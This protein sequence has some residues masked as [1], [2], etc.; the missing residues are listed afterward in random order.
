MNRAAACADS[1]A[2]YRVAHSVAGAARNV[3]ADRLAQRASA[4]EQKVGSLSPAE[5][6]AELAA[7]R[8]DLDGTLERKKISA[9]PAG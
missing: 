5:L 9:M 7:M 8:A 2:I 1:N 4:L 6:V 3:G